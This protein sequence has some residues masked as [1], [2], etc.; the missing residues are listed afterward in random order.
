[1]S[2]EE[3]VPKLTPLTDWC[4]QTGLGYQRAYHLATRGHIDAIQL[5]ARWYVKGS[6]LPEESEGLKD[7]GRDE[8][9]N[10]LGESG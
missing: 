3:K 10:E 1:M 2:I 9:R 7:G 4:E 6:G 5:G 8:N